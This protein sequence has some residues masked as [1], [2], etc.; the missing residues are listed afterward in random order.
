M[1][2]GQVVDAAGQPI[3]G[4]CVRAYP[5]RQP[6]LEL[7]TAADGTFVVPS[8]S[9][10]PVYVLEIR[11]PGCATRM[12]DLGDGSP[13]ART[14]QLRPGMPLLVQVHDADGAIPSHV[15]VLVR[16]DNGKGWQFWTD[17]MPEVEMVEPGTYTVIAYGKGCRLERRLVVVAAPTTVD[18]QLQPASG[19]TIRFHVSGADPTL[20][21]DAECSVEVQFDREHV[22]IR[23]SSLHGKPD[24]HGVF[25]RSGLPTDATLFLRVSVP[26]MRTDPPEARLAPDPREGCIDMP[27][28]LRQRPTRT[29]RG[30][31][32]DGDGRGIGAVSVILYAAHAGKSECS[33]DVDGRFVIETTACDGELLRLWLAPG[34]RVFDS[35]TSLHY[36][37]QRARHLHVFV[38]PCATEL[39]LPTRPAPRP[40]G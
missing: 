7:V 39:V 31:V 3:A 2:R 1:I 10:A 38:L 30:R 8:I 14:F 25:E 6:Y 24:A 18:L 37:R 11:A 28:V 16:G 17:A 19:R 5:Q 34:P 4:A 9:T 32:V 35:P 13:E 27:F 15:E 23:L 40:E 26:G 33:T 29:V 22:P 12:F 36:H 21:Q 20:V